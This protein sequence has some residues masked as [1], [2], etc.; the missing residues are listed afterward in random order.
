MCTVVVDIDPGAKVPLV[1]AGA[2][3]GLADRPW[4]PPD[5]HR[6]GP[7]GGRDLRAGGTRPR[8]PAAFRRVPVK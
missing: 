7:V 5:R 4:V 1:L 3:D 8:D 6:P 2:C